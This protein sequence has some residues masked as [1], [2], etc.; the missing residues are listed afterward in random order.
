MPD[1][2]NIDSRCNDARS[3]ADEAAKGTE[4][5]SSDQA[6]AAEQT[7]VKCFNLPKLNPDQDKQRYLILCGAAAL[8]LA[9]LKSTGDEAKALFKKADSIAAL[10]GGVV[11]DRSNGIKTIHYDPVNRD[12]T[13]PAEQMATAMTGPSRQTVETTKYTD[14]RDPHQNGQVLSFSAVASQI[15]AGVAAHLAPTFQPRV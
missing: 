10:L 11:S 2:Q 7:F 14:V 13:D 5:I 9:A 4:E 15:R 3:F 8:Y 12:S 1:R 6:I